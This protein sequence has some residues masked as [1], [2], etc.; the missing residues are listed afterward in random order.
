MNWKKEVRKISLLAD[1]LYFVIGETI[2]LH[3]LSN[4]LRCGCF[5]Q[6]PHANY[7][8]IYYVKYQN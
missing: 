1:A 2:Y 5:S 8:S 4:L 3:K 7:K 6:L